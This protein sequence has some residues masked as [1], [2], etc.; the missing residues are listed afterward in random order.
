MNAI[1]QLCHDTRPSFASQF[2]TKKTLLPDAAL[3]LRNRMRLL[4]VG[5]GVTVLM[6]A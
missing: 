4:L 3:Q 6:Y 5:P 1:Q 2:L